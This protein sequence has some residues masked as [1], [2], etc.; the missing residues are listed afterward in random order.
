MR[1]FLQDQAG[2]RAHVTPVGD[3][4]EVGWSFAELGTSQDSNI[5][6]HGSLK[7]DSLIQ[8]RSI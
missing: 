7:E 1:G 6:S 2:F 5:T 3:V 4:W 8:E